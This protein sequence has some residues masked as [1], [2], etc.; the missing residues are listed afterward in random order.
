MLKKMIGLGAAMALVGCGGGGGDSGGNSGGNTNTPSTPQCTATQYLEANVCKNKA[1]QSITDLRISNSLTVGAKA[2]ISAIT[3]S[4]LAVAYSSK[5]PS[6]CSVSGDQ[7]TAIKAGECS[8][9]ANQAGDAKTLAADEVVG[10]AIVS[11]LVSASKLTQTGIITCGNETTNGLLCTAD[12]LGALY[13]LGQDG[14]VQA[15]E[16]MSYTLL[17]QNGADCVKDNVTGLLWEQKIDDGSLRDTDWTYTW[18]STDS[19]SNGGAAGFQDYRDY[20]SKYTRSTCG[21]S[22]SKCNT[23]AYVAALNAANYCGYSDWRM[24]TRMELIGLVDYGR[25]NSSINPVFVNTPSAV[26]YWSA[27]SHPSIGASA[28]LVYFANG[29]TYDLYKGGAFHVRAV[30]AGQ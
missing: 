13:G 22:L 18:Y 15:G 21:N 26:Y 24:P 1:S 27:S 17:T 19:A 11:G 8:L 30:R 28:W 6:V 14:E 29:D 5:T 2:T 20:D 12:A 23:Q 3:S 25:V 7:V 10:R 16:K 9:A 4:G